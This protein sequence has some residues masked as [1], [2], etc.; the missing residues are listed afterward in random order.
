M[1]GG[2]RI[3][4][5]KDEINVIE[6]ELRRTGNTLWKM[7]LLANCRETNQGVSMALYFFFDVHA[8]C[9]AF[10][11]QYAAAAANVV[12]VEVAAYRRTCRV[13]TSIPQT[14]FCLTNPWCSHI[15]SLT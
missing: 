11:P 15:H 9:A 3:A 10:N 6:I 4:G 7:Y 2:M 1:A 14:N 12:Y 5:R 13:E 8:T